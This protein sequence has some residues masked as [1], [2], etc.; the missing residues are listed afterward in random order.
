MSMHQR[1]WARLRR[2]VR[3]SPVRPVPAA[4]SHPGQQVVEQEPW[5]IAVARIS[6]PHTSGPPTMPQPYQPAAVRA[7]YAPVSCRTC[8]TASPPHCEADLDPATVRLLTALEGLC[9]H[10]RRVVPERPA[11]MEGVRHTSARDDM[12]SSL[13]PRP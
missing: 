9:P 6:L 10:P 2:A 3:R 11:H 12:P 8:S 4:E 13:R 7:H 1:V 5:A